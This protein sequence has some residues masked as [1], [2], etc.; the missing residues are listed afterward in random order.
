MTSH[1][2]ADGAVL[3]TVRGPGLS[4]AAAA[5]SAYAVFSRLVSPNELNVIVVGASLAPGELFTVPIGAIN[6]LSAY[7]VRI[8]QVA[9]QDDSLRSDLSQYQAS[10]SSH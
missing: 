10:L 4:T 7:S 1:S 2:A 9:S 8:E 3:I 5:N 6:R